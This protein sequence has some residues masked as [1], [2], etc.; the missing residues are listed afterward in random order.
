MTEFHWW[1]TVLRLTPRYD[2]SVCSYLACFQKYL[3]C[4]Q[5][6]VRDLPPHGPL[7]YRCVCITFS[8]GQQQGLPYPFLSVQWQFNSPPF[9]SNSIFNVYPKSVPYARP[10]TFSSCTVPLLQGNEVVSA[11]APGHSDGCYYSTMQS[12]SRTASDL[13]FCWGCSQ[14][15]VQFLMCTCIFFWAE[16]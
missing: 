4:I 6:R 1:A 7:K 16:W 14:F 15:C 12:C 5:W 13:L 9:Q 2:L 11:K 10:E 8:F 3:V